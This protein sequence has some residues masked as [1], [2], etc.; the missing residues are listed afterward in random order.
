MRRLWVPLAF[1][2][3]CA[4]LAACG[5]GSGAAAQTAPPQQ[6]AAASCPAPGL[7]R[8]D[9]GDL[10]VPSAAR[11]GRT[12]LLVVVIPGTRGDRHDRLG[13]WRAARARGMAVLYP[14]GNGFWTLNDT[15][16]RTDVED[17]TKLLDDVTASGCFDAKRL[18]ITGVSNG[19][20]FA[21][22]MTCALPG[23]FAALI[24]VSAGYRALDPCPASARTSFLAIHGTGDTVVPYN[25]KKPD[26]KGN[27]PRFTAAWARRDGCAA[28]TASHPVRLV[29]RY[30]WT[31]CGTGLRVGL[32]RLTGSE[33]GWPG[34]R[35]RNPS[36]FRATPEVVRFAAAA[37][38]S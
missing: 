35:G 28:R 36:G 23:R 2:V 24:P 15:Q 38:R 6:R 11:P 17:V 9:G 8:V 16:G 31:G 13:V 22:R 27:V 30:R 19:A 32:I 21:T 20:G 4:V 5:G 12:P 10:R 29:T 33:H 26:R 14:A 7:H 18:S 34:V 3:P 37:R 1:G 25:G